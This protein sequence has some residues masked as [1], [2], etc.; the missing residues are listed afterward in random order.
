MRLNYYFS[1]VLLMAVVFLACKDRAQEEATSKEAMDEAG[2]SSALPKRFTSSPD[3]V[4]GSA[5]PVS[6]EGMVWI[7]AGQFSMGAADE[8]GRQNEYP[9]HEVKVNGFWIDATE[10]TNA[11]F[12]QFTEATG[13]ITTAE[14]APDWNEIK[15]QLPPGTPK[16]PDSLLTASSL[17]FTPPGQPVPLT[18]ISQWWS[19][20]K[21][22]DWKH[23]QGPA[24]SIAG[25]DNYP[26]V[27][28]SWD[29]AM[30]YAKWAGKSLPT[31]AEWEF[32]S[33]G[34]LKEQRYPWGNED[35]EKGKPKA[36][37]WQGNFPNQ[38]TEWDH[39]ERLAPVKSFSANGYGLYDMAGNVWEWTADW[40]DAR[41]YTQLKGQLADNPAGP[42][43][44]YDPMEPT[45]PKKTVRGGSFMC[46]A[47]YCKG[48]RVTSRMS[49]STD[50][51][52]EHTGFR[53]VAR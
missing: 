35:V 28:V 22:A 33:R 6:H 9:Q 32:A 1:W 20:K 15:K 17:V 43:S 42:A 41:Y 40:Y 25:K 7:P 2:C 26:V 49:S 52:L 31:E 51:G 18:D 11:Q 34:G 24:S 50:T 14:K 4:A 53:C 45:V 5:Q 30:A 8:E 16:P 39:F 38:N 47:S 3:T 36:N 21:G 29:D 10:V 27:H 19:W 44:S 37:T 13:Y 23:P 46:N 48:Y 12:R